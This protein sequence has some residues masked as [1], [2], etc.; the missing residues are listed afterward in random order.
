MRVYCIDNTSG[1]AR[2]LDLYSCYDAVESDEP[3]YYIIMIRPFLEPNLRG[4]RL[5]M[6]QQVWVDNNAFIT[7]EQWRQRQLKE[8]GV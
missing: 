5:E 3:G 7:L 2:H 1:N 4:R 8:L 6:T